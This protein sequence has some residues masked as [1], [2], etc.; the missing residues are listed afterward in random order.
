MIKSKIKKIKQEN[1]AVRRFLSHKLA[2]FGMIFLIMLIILA[3]L[4]PLIVNHHPYSQD[5]LASRKPPTRN[6]IL[7]TD[8]LGRDVFS[9]LLY[10]ARIS[11]LVGLG[12]VS[13][14]VIIGTILGAVAGYF[15]GITENIIM[16]FT[17]TMLCFPPIIVAL[18]LIA[19]MGP[20]IRNVI[21]VIAVLR[22]PQISRIV[23]GQFLYLR[24]QEFVMAA[25]GLGAKNVKIIFKHILPNVVGLLV[26]ATSF[27]MAETILMEA[28]LSF[29]GFGVEPPI[30]T[31]GNMIQ[32][33]QSLT[34]LKNMPWL[35]LPP[36]L[37][38]FLTVLSINF[39]GDG[40]RDALDPRS[41][42]QE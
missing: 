18:A 12:A 33:A 40:L 14:Y 2:I 17:D 26:V 1:K 41:I 42:T 15:G 11:L 19:I 25:R 4:A 22:W 10:G 13:L 31:W 32:A 23:R 9:R 30:P 8:T 27:G 5:L 28:W 20:S 35:W 38:I 34:V 7:G 16:R 36:G 39:V 37:A 3:I 21:L 29:L 24:E 6:H